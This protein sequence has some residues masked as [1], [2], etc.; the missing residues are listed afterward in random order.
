MFV[1]YVENKRNQKKE[2]F[3]INECNFVSVYPPS[4]YYFNFFL[5][6]LNVLGE[7][8]SGVNVDSLSTLWVCVCFI[9][10][11]ID[12]EKKLNK[13]RFTCLKLPCFGLL[14]FLLNCMTEGRIRTD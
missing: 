7:F 14:I 13:I 5:L 4:S 2:W 1:I 9:R 3:I 12:N 10:L 8:Y 6:L 11:L